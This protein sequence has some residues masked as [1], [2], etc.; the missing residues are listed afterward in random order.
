MKKRIL[1]LCLAAVM[2]LGMLPV[3]AAA[4]AAE[5]VYLAAYAAAVTVDGTADE[6]VWALNGQMTGETDR[7]FGALWNLETLWLAAVPQ[8]GDGA[9]T[10]TVAGRTLTV[11]AD[12][13]CSGDLAAAAEAA[14]GTA[15]EVAIPM[16]A[17]GV[18]FEDYGQT[19][20]LSASLGGASWEGKLALN[21]LERKVL[22]TSFPSAGKMVNNVAT[23]V[24]NLGDEPVGN[25]FR[26]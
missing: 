12:G 24:E 9:L 23:T 1:A 14:C 5:P 17:L 7:A 2:L 15:V 16:S 21:S 22:Q 6:V 20:D 18:S 4:E 8:T 13:T 3:G 11:A 26:T 19:V 25:G 10:L